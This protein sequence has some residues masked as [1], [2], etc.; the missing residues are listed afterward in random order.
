MSDKSGLIIYECVN[1]PCVMTD[2]LDSDEAK[3]QSDFN[4]RHHSGSY[5]TQTDVSWQ[6]AL[7]RWWHE[8]KVQSFVTVVAFVLVF[9]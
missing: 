3:M 6:A 2:T 4:S 9:K 7:S 8:K 5:E 1:I